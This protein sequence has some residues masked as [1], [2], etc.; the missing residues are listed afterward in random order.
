MNFN[1]AEITSLHVSVNG[2]PVEVQDDAPNAAGGGPYNVTLEMV[3][4]AGVAGPYTLITTCSDISA[5]A[6]AP[7][8]LIPPA[9]S[10]NGAG[11][12]ATAPW[13]PNGPLDFVFNE[14]VTVGPEPAADKG[15][16]YQYTAA[17]FNNNGQIVSI[18]QSDPFILL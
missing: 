15:H 18:K 3:A 13:K 11:M 5:T 16:A 1:D 6:A 17:L 9:G 10:L 14:S 4:G 8:A 12:F 2:A 7:A